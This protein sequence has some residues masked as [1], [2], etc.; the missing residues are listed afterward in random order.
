MWNPNMTQTNLL[1]K[2]KQNQTQK[3]DL[4]LLKVVGRDGLGGLGLTDIQTIIYIAWINNKIL[5]IAQ[6][7]IFNVLGYTIMEKNIGKNV[8][9][10]PGGPVAKTS[11]FQCRGPGSIPGQGTRSHMLQPRC[12]KPQQRSKIPCDSTKIWHSQINK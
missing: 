7:T 8:G 10:F 11:Y 1:L 12:H 5:L 3:T 9:H 4:C 6:G 2:Q